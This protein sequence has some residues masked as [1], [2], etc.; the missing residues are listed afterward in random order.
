VAKRLT[1]W[2]T[3]LG[4]FISLGLFVI[5]GQVFFKGKNNESVNDRHID[6]YWKI[7]KALL[8]PEY[9]L[10]VPPWK[11][12]ISQMFRGAAHKGLDI[13]VDSGTPVYS[14]SSGK[15]V[16][17]SWDGL[18][19]NMIKIDT[20]GREVFLYGHLKTLNVSVG[21]KV[22]VGKLIGRSGSTGFS[23]GPHLHLGLWLHGKLSDPLP[24][25]KKNVSLYEWNKKH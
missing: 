8:N 20:G 16:H 3:A 7:Q 11:W 13:A 22:K 25:L 14:V 10:P 4:S 6:N 15:V 23:S 18:Y 24:W 12:E 19:G 1:I 9:V 21:D 5:T 17:S 2:L